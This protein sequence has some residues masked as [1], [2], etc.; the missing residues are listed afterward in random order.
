LRPN[1]SQKEKG[2]VAGNREEKEEKKEETGLYE[3]KR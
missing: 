1:G 2:K 3:A